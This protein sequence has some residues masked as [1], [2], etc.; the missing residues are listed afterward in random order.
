MD[1]RIGYDMINHNGIIWV[2]ICACVCI[3]HGM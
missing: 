3:V 2:Y 1:D